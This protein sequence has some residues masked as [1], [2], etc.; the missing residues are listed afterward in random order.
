MIKDDTLLIRNRV[1]DLIR[2]HPEFQ[3]L[4]AGIMHEGLHAIWGINEGL[5]DLLLK[6]LERELSYSFIYS[7]DGALDIEK[8]K[9]FYCKK[10]DKNAIMSHIQEHVEKLSYTRVDKVMNIGEYSVKG[11]IIDVYTTEYVTRFDYFG[12]EI[13]NIFLIDPLTGSIEY[14][15]DFAFIPFASSNMMVTSYDLPLLSDR[16]LLFN[17]TIHQHVYTFDFE[18]LPF[19]FSNPKLFEFELKK[20]TGG[21]VI[22]SSHNEDYIEKVKEFNI[23]F[24]IQ[25]FDERFPTGFSSKALNTS[26][27]TDKELSG[28]LNLNLQRKKKNENLLLIGEINLGDLIVH[29]DHGVGIYRGVLKKEVLGVIRE[30][31]FLEYAKEDKLYVPL[32]QLVKLTKY[33]GSHGERP[34]LTRLGTMEWE[35]AKEKVKK[36]VQDIARELLKLYALRELAEKKPISG[37]NLYYKELEDSFAYDLTADQRTAIDEVEKDME[38]K[39]PMDRVIVGDVGYGKTEVA[40]RAAFKVVTSGMQVAVLSPTTILCEQLTEVFKERL[41]PFSVR[42]ESL[43]RFQGSYKNAQVIKELN[44]G[45]VDIVIGTHRLLQ[46]DIHF[47]NLGLLII[48]EEQRFGVKQKEK[49]KALRIDTNVL[50]MSAT[51]IPRTLHM[52]LSGAKDISVINTP[53]KGRMPIKTHIIERDWNKLKEV[54]EAEVHKGGQVYFVHNRVATILSVRQRL[55]DLMPDIKF[56]EAHGQ[57]MSTKLESIIEDFRG[58]EYDVLIASTIIENGIDIPNVNTI[59]INNAQ[60]FGLS[61]LYQ[62]RGRVG[63]SDTQSY[64]YLVYPENYELEGPARQRLY[65]IMNAQDLG[66]GF[67]IAIKDLEI[68]GAGNFLGKEQHGDISSVGFELFTKLLSSEVA[69]MREEL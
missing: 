41:A 52:A 18:P 38:S 45:K 1:I 29:E 54:I 51:P 27:F 39:R 37:D 24:N 5:E 28:R 67:T 56:I 57:M 40:V 35:R 30:Y 2:L 16:V 12:D 53:P 44:E 19:V 46:E 49:L 21:L 58:Q 14:N 6:S 42:I 50:S 22:I 4:K 34:H 3:T 65:A 20:I 8:T 69:K 32:D 13:E 63:R 17:S 60:K 31:I 66:A 59:I 10:N 25:Y 43:S 36:S 68:R 33:I 61:Q 47:S 23:P 7:L 9:F 55:Q 11:G 48:D 64:C 26:L 62:L 15:V